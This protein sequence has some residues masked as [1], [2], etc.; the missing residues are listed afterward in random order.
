MWV[1]VGI[2]LLV[3]LVHITLSVLLSVRTEAIIP[4]LKAMY[5]QLEYIY[6]KRKNKRVERVLAYFVK[7]EGDC[8]ADVSRDKGG[9]IELEQQCVL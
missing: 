1:E 6:I 4:L 8:D 3:V 2:G 5:T 9:G 7:T